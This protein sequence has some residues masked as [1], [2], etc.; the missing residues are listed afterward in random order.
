M[1][2]ALQEGS[3]GMVSQRDLM[4][5]FNK[6]AQL[7][8]V[9]FATK[10]PEAMG[11]LGK[12]AQSTGQDMD[13]MLN[14]LVLGVGRMS[15][16]IL[17]NLGI[18]ASLAEATQR[19]AQ[20]FGVE[21]EALSKAQLQAGMMNVV[22]EKLAINT[23]S[24]P[25]IANT[26][27]ASMAQL[28]AGLAD[29]SAQIGGF[30]LPA[31]GGAVGAL[32]D[33][34]TW[35]QQAITE[36]GFLYPVMLNL[37][38]AASLLTDAF[39]TLGA[40]AREAGQSVFEQFGGQ[41][42]ATA[43]AAF[44]WGINIVTQLASGIIQ[45]AAAALTTAMNYVASILS[46]F[47]APGSPP[48]VAPDIDKWGQAAMNEYLT[49]FTTASF[50]ILEGIQG[51]LSNVLS[52]LVMTGA[53]AAE[54][55]AA[56]FNAIG[57]D[58]THAVSEFQQDGALLE[59]LLTRLGAVGG[60]FGEQ[61]VELARRQFSMAEA[62]DRLRQATEALALAQEDHVEAQSDV[63]RIADEYNEMLLRGASYEELAAKRAE[64]LAAERRAAQVKE[65]LK[66]AEVE[67]KAAEGQID[68]ER[69]RLNLQSR[70][71]D[72]MELLARTQADMVAAI[73]V[74]VLRFPRLAGAPVAASSYRSCP[75][76]PGWAGASRGG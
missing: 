11:Y 44:S 73:L 29:I 14:S 27:A 22:L 12:V 57:A 8:S 2:R 7:V 45:G 21:A 17:D 36:G 23:A 54:D 62:T 32:R 59:G 71:I 72:Q 50:D 56:M 66:A 35:A 68:I 16:M 28:R 1:I 65:T 64:K 52:T 20:M 69:E 25:D 43:N 24:M 40:R 13:Y 55:A 51:P 41:L 75:K 26:A 38:A 47:L 76:S 3:A 9:D 15:P 4:L 39:G 60:E 61:L 58:L 6:A 74:V 46:W 31:Y 5:S 37:G 33:F 67:K 48:R 63:A 10:L 42:T 19:A 49:G 34:V 30:F 18:Q 53:M 70:L